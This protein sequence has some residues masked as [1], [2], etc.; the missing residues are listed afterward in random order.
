MLMRRF[1]IGMLLLVLLAA[2]GSQP[3]AGAPTSVLPPTSAPAV[4]A[5]PSPAAAAIPTEAPTAPAAAE[6]PTA[7]AGD[8]PTLTLMTHDSFSVSEDVLK[9]FEQQEKVRV[10]VLKS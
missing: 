8:Q 2:C 10:Q 3:S 7:P 4:T 1:S 5:A 9:E 6:A